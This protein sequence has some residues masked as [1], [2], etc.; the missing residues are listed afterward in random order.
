M[1]LRNGGGMDLREG[2]VD[3]LE[4]VKEGKAVLDVLK[5]K[6]Q[7]YTLDYLSCH[8]QLDLIAKNK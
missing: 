1:I 8:K 5:T 2:G 4:G 7:K 6:R 3:R